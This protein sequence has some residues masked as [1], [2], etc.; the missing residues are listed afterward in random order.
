MTNNPETFSNG[1]IG[2]ICDD[3]FTFLAANGLYV[4]SFY[5]IVFLGVSTDGKNW[6]FSVLVSDD[7]NPS[8]LSQGK[9]KIF[10]LKYSH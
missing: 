5:D 9:G 3:A 6:N 7:F 2:T 8:G 4:A 1:L 10:S